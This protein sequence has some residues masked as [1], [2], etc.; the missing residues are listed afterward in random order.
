[1][2]LRPWFS[3]LAT[4]PSTTGG[5]SARRCLRYGT[6]VVRDLSAASAVVLIS[7]AAPLVLSAA[8]PV[9]L[10]SCD[11]VSNTPHRG[12]AHSVCDICVGQLRAC[13]LC[14]APR[15]LS[16]VSSVVL[17]SRVPFR[18]LPSGVGSIWFAR[19]Y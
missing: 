1:M 3:L 2:R 6:W 18:A 12:G 14:L 11:S 15:D 5:S 4:Q 19:K 9:V 16:A 13:V 17:I 8:P 10:I 7:L